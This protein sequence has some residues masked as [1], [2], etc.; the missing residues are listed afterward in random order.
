MTS[1]NEPGGVNPVGQERSKPR[2]VRAANGG[3][4]RLNSRALAAFFLL[5]YAISWAAWAIPVLPSFAPMLA[6][7]TKS[8]QRTRSQL[9]LD[10]LVSAIPIQALRYGDAVRACASRFS[11]TAGAAPGPSGDRLA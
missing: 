8:S 4:A 2:S 7:M 6:A 3:T 9:S 5:A 11:A 1:R 10:L